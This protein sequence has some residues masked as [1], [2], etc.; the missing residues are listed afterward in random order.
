MLVIVG[1]IYAAKV[2]SNAITEQIHAETS[3]DESFSPIK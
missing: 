3:N 1:F 2:I